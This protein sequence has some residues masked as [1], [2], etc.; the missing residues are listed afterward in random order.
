MLELMASRGL[1]PRRRMA[2][3]FLSAA[4]LAC[5]CGGDR[6]GGHEGD[7]GPDSA[8]D[9]DY[10]QDTCSESETETVDTDFPSDA[11][12]TTCVE[13]A[14][15]PTSVGCEFFM[16]DLDISQEND[17]S[18]KPYVVVVSNPQQ[19]QMASITL[20]DGTDGEIYSTIL[21]PGQL[22][23]IYVACDSGCLVPPHQIETQ[24]YAAGAGFQLTSE[25]PVLAYQWNPYGVDMDDW[26]NADASLLIP[27]ASLDGTYIVAA[28]GIGPD[29]DFYDHFSQ[30]TIVATEDGTNL[31]F[32]PSVGVPAMGGA[33]PYP[34]DVETEA[35]ALDAFDVVTLSP[36]ATDDDITGT[37]VHADKPVVVFGSHSCALV[38][39]KDF[40]ACDHVEE[41]MIPLEA[42][43]TSSVLA[44]H[45][46]RHNCVSEDLV[47]WRIISGAADM[48]VV[49]DPPAPEPAGAEHHFTQQGEVLE[50]LAPNDYYV[51]GV[52]ESPEDPFH[53]G[54]PFLAYQLMTGSDFPDCYLHD[55]YD[56]EGDP[57]MLLAPPAG[58][59]L[60][61][62]V[63]NTE[64]VG[65]FDYDHIII[66]RPPGAHVALDCLGLI[67]DSEFSMV[68]ASGW[69]V[70]RVYIDDP[71]DDTGCVD[72]AHLLTASEPVGLS[73]VGTALAVSYGYLGGIGVRPINPVIE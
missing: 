8:V 14:A 61:R 20:R 69:E 29:N 40:G 31:S 48:R 64:N 42:W 16:A 19:D 21:N 54:A 43:G 15:S 49:F 53:P 73:V 57:L 5:H 37:F 55:G 38:P 34:A 45:A 25:V 72:G 56:R 10:S 13:A 63:F 65:D 12:P 39:N 2:N 32:V 50:F 33:G 23:V 6:H 41:Q 36:A 62:Y 30:V 27:K 66:V 46:P 26:G 68:G 18:S 11:I 1:P 51:E 4:L 47:L 17:S 59:Y 52:F 7:G 70:A 3:L 67:P 71:L 35:I 9:T 44:R 22:D 58:Q 28:W 60:D 24:G